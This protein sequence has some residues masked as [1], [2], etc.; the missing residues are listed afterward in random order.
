MLCSIFIESLFTPHKNNH[1]TESFFTGE[2]FVAKQTDKK[3]KKK[4]KR[5]EEK[6]LGW[7][8]L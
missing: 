5:V 8:N 1:F 3:K 4:L 7:G 2:V 6:I